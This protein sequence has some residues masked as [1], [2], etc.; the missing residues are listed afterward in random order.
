LA[1][2]PSSD[3]DWRVAPFDFT[4]APGHLIRRAQQLHAIVWR[5]LVGDALTSV[6]FAILV[7]LDA[8]TGI[9][10]RT[11][12]E[13]VSLDT[14]STAEVCARLLERDLVARERDPGDRRRYVLSLTARGVATL[15]ET[16]PLVDEVGRRLLEPLPAGE[17]AELMRLLLLLLGV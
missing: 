5:E 6:Q 12:A 16:V 14:S 15:H 4:S 3:D 1:S 10:Q 8:E 2:R 7:A 11:L 9:D 17:R 13:R